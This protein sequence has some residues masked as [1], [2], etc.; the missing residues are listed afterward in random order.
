[1]DHGPRGKMYASQLA[2]WYLPGPF[3]TQRDP[4]GP[5]RTQRD[6]DFFAAVPRR[7]RRRRRAIL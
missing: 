3:G 2:N 5:N 6:H 1:M 7:S 4:T